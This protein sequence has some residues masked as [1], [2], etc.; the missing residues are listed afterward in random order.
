MFQSNKLSGLP[1]G[2]FASDIIKGMIENDRESRSKLP[3]VV[4]KLLKSTSS[5]IDN[6]EKVIYSFLI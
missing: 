1:I 6:D 5:S 4:K 3:D 2:H